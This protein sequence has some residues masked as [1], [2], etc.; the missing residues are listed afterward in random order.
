[1]QFSLAVAQWAAGQTIFF[2]LPL[3]GVCHP[4]D[5]KDDSP[6]DALHRDDLRKQFAAS[7]INRL[8]AMAQATH[9]STLTTSNNKASITLAWALKKSHRYDIVILRSPPPD[10]LPGLLGVVLRVVKPAVV[11]TLK[12]VAPVTRAVSSL[13]PAVTPIPARI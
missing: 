2:R 3:L 8:K 7:H 10:Y 11:N 1:M 13:C 5:R 4:L 9:I 12:L 6:G